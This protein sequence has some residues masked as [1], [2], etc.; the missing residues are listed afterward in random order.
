MAGIRTSSDFRSCFVRQSLILRPLNRR[1]L[2]LFPFEWG[3]IQFSRVLISSLGIYIKESESVCPEIFSQLNTFPK[4]NWQKQNMFAGKDLERSLTAFK[5]LDEVWPN[6]TNTHFLTGRIFVLYFI[7]KMRKGKFFVKERESAPPAINW[8]GGT[9]RGGDGW[10]QRQK[11]SDTS[12][13][14]YRLI[15]ESDIEHLFQLWPWN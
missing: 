12:A 5:L 11:C 7:A 6:W 9:G 13:T 1:D 3:D 10:V 15:H 4:R 8:M 14:I 2:N